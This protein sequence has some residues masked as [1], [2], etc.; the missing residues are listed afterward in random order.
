M[1]VAPDEA[2]MLDLCVAESCCGGS[3]AGSFVPR[4][5]HTLCLRFIQFIDLVIA[6]WT[7]TAFG[8]LGRERDTDL[9]VVEAADLRISE[10]SCSKMDTEDPEDGLAHLSRNSVRLQPIS[11]R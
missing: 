8:C 2:P 9:L 5:L 7:L 3:I 4:F 6:L 11:P 1:V 10:V